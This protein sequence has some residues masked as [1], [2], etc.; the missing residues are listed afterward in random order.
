MIDVKVNEKHQV[1]RIHCAGGPVELAAEVGLIIGSMYAEVSALNPV[2]AEYLKKLLQG[3]TLDES[4]AWDPPPAGYRASGESA[5]IVMP[6]LR[7]DD[8]S[9]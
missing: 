3:A 4:P 8:P 7:R 2:A 1:E 6:R 9:V 5:V